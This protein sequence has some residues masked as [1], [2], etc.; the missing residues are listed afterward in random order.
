MWG[1]GEG[2]SLMTAPHAPRLTRLS[3]A[4][5]PEAAVAALMAA[6]VVALMA[7]LVAAAAALKTALAV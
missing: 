7:A 3:V 1:Q 4:A 2:E 6:L 5:E